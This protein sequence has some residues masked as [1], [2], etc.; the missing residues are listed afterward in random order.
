MKLGFLELPAEERRL[1]IEQAAALRNASPVILEKDFWVCWL[2]GLPGLRRD[3]QAMRDMYL[4]E[5][6]SFDGILATLA[7][8][9]NRINHIGDD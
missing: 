9:E 1:Y 4:V 6:A 7:E 5:P 3:Y 8:L 2:L